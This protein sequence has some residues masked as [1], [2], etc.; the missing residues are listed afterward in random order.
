L[1]PSQISIFL[2]ILYVCVFSQKYE[3]QYFSLLHIPQPTFHIFF[4]RK[5]I[6]K[7]KRMSSQH[8]FV[9]FSS[10][11]MSSATYLTDKKKV[12]K[13]RVTFIFIYDKLLK[14][15]T[16]HIDFDIV[17]QG[18]VV[19]INFKGRNESFLSFFYVREKK[20]FDCQMKFMRVLFLNDT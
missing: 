8:N 16:F 6:W 11:S 14:V 19:R 18:N 13:S 15:N 20:T 2:F 5:L 10:S 9:V 1:K 17:C 3:W 12:W 4:K 7:N